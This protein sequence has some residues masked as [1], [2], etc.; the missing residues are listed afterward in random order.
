MTKLRSLVNSP[1]IGENPAWVTAFHTGKIK[2]CGNA[3]VKGEEN[4]EQSLGLIIG[5]VHACVKQ[6]IINPRTAAN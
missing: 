2:P 4:V 3:S 1:A 6:L 5:A